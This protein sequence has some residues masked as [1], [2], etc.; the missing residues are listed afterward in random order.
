MVYEPME[1]I[2]QIEQGNGPGELPDGAQDTARYNFF[3]KFLHYAQSTGST[4][5]QHGPKIIN[6]VVYS[7]F[8]TTEF[9]ITTISARKM[10]T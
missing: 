6:A 8:A 3:I 1:A 4:G 2:D 5:L 10:N 7:V 9:V